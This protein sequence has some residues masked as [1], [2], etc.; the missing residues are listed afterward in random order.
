MA[1]VSGNAVL[2]LGSDTITL[3]GVA[4]SDLHVDDYFGVMAGPTSGDDTLLG[5]SGNDTIDGLAGNDSIGGN[6]GNDFLR[7]GAGDDAVSGNAGDD[8][9]YGDAG[10]DILN[11][12]A[13][14]DT[15][16]GG[17]GRDTYTF[18]AGF[19]ADTISDFTAGF[20][21][22]DLQ[23]LDLADFN[24]L[25]AATADVSGNAVITLSGNTITLTG[26]TKSQLLQSDF[27]G[28]NPVGTSG[29]D[30]INGFDTDDTINGLAG[31][32]II[33]GGAGDDTLNG[34]D[35]DD[36]LVGGAGADVMTGGNGDD[37]YL[38]DNVGDT[39]TEGSIASTDTVISSISFTLGDHVENLEL[40]L[41]SN[42]DGT[43][44]N[45]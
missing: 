36:R 31:N 41:S 45:L 28:V 17:A 7:G 39:V 8:T 35:G 33:N 24:A 12:G 44:N 22:I 42:I 4:S 26:V 1:D 43:G 2:T 6:G 32:D 30:V 27:V 15:L 19:G 11:G 20:D 34:G 23:A 3:T 37:T 40:S 29:N 13:G 16:I 18:S 10:S 21:S 5:T 25:L 38:V 14:D 9:L